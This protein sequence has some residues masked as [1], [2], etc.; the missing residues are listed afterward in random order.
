RIAIGDTATGTQQQDLQQRFLAVPPD[1]LRPLARSIFLGDT[2]HHLSSVT[3]PS[4]F[5]RPLGMP[6]CP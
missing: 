4:F 2:R 1:V 3:V 6:L 5:F